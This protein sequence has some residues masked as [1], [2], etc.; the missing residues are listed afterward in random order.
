MELSCVV[1]TSHGYGAANGTKFSSYCQEV[2][3]YISIIGEE[4]LGFQLG[5]YDV[6]V[7]YIHRRQSYLVNLPTLPAQAIIERGD[8]NFTTADESITLRFHPSALPNN[9]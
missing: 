9:V 5:P 6:S 3:I 2:A 4:E 1:V 7:T 8:F